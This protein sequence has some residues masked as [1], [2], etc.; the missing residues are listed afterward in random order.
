MHHMSKL[1]DTII[2]GAGLSGIHIA[3]KLIEAGESVL[4]LE[5]SRN[6]GG[7]IAN[8]RFLKHNFALG[9]NSFQ[10][11]NQDLIMY[12]EKGRKSGVLNYSCAHY[13]SNG[14]IT[15]WTKSLLGKENI[16]LQELVHR[17]ES[18]TAFNNVYTESSKYQARKVIICAP[19][20]QSFSLLKNSGLNL[21]EL[22][23]VL[24]SQD[25]FYYTRTINTLDI[26][27]WTKIS[28]ARENNYLYAK[29]KKNDWVE[30]DRNALRK[31]LDKKYVP[32]ESHLHK[33]RYSQVLRTLNPRYQIHFKD[34][35]IYLAGDYF[36]GSD[37][38]SAIASS[39]FL[40]NQLS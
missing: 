39:N 34:K 23:D 9:L 8:R 3:N 29:F 18:F 12:A 25:I 37:L 35:G 1:Y 26:K 13:F 24:Y 16:K 38:N 6:I 14:D 22:N 15:K 4:I 31:E 19:A 2:I 27:G 17:I 28:E 5:K 21:Y 30:E 20:H 11:W 36:F 7:R 33:W 32:F 10:A 40:I